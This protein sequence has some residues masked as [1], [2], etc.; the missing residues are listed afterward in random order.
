MSSTNW[1]TTESLRVSREPRSVT[2]DAIRND[3]PNQ[4][5]FGNSYS[6]DRTV[7]E[8]DHP[9]NLSP[10]SFYDPSQVGGVCTP[11]P[12]P[13][14]TNYTGRYEGSLGRNTFRGPNFQEIDF[15]V[16]KNI[17]AGERANLQFR[18]E[19]FNLFNR[20][21]LQMPSATFGFSTSLFGLTTQ[22]Y[23]ARQIQFALRLSF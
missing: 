6:N 2:S 3:R 22:A 8:A 9:T 12:V 20:T 18:A 5:S 21:N 13:G 7:F 1:R 16:F 10:T 4:P 14:C 19:A 11:S 17:K 23:A 15:S